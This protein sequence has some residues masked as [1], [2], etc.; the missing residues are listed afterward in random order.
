MYILRR[1]FRNVPLLILAVLLM[2]TLIPAAFQGFSGLMQQLKGNGDIAGFFTP[3]V[4]HWESKIV[5]WASIY[6]VDPN[7]LATVMQI[8]SCGHPNVASSA[9]AQGLFQVMPFHFANGEVM[10]DPDTNAMRGATVLKE[11][12]AFVGDNVGMILACYN[13]GPSVASRA[14]SSWPA[15]TQ[16][17]YLW[18]ANIYNDAYHHL[19]NSPTLTDWL[20]AGG[21]TLCNSAEAELGM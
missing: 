16:R 12:R 19:S 20:N 21:R 15:E 1:L 4:I 7:L 2:P 8:E 11:C 10:L 3:S 6:D 13:G 18:G 5:S 9:G 17:Y 14:F